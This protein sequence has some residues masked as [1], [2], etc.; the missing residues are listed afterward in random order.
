MKRTRNLK[1]KTKQGQY[2]S[3]GAAYKAMQSFFDRNFGGVVSPN[4][5]V[6]SCNGH[7]HWGHSRDRKR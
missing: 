4:A 3:R 7:F 2:E 6:Y 5:S 1:C